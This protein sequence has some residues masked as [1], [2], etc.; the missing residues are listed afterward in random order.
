MIDFNGVEQSSM[1][2]IFRRPNYHIIMIKGGK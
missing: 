2:V 1:R